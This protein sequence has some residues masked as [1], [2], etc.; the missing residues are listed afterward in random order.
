V[1]ERRRPTV[2]RRFVH[3]DDLFDNRIYGKGACILHMLRFTVGEELWLKGLRDYT[4]QYAFQSIETSQ[5]RRSFEESTGYNLERFFD[6]WIYGAG[7]PQFEISSKW[8]QALRSVILTVTQVQ[9]PDSLT[10]LFTTPVE[11]EVWVNGVPETYREMITGVT[12]EFTYPAYQE[13]QLVIF[14]KGSNLLKTAKFDKGIGQWI[15]QLRNADHVADRVAAISELRWMVDSATVKQALLEALIG[16]RAWGVRREAAWAL[17]D[18]KIP[19]GEE[20]LSAYGD[21][22]ARVRTAVIAALGKSGGEEVVRTLRRAFRSDS[23]Y[24]VSAR[25]LRSLVSADSLNG[26][27]YCYEGLTMDSYGDAIRSAA[28]RGL[29]RYRADESVRDTLIS[30][31]RLGRPRT[32]RVLSIAL[33]ARHWKDDDDV[34]DHLV[35]FLDDPGFRVRRAAVM[36]LGNT[37]YD[38]ALN[39]LRRRLVSEPNS[40]IQKAIREAIKKIEDKD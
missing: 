30:Y 29:A 10:G 23:S 13:P 24:N 8:D 34:L 9:I 4:A 20:M 27:E 36:N 40:R 2:T 14:D 15:F 28:L 22:N 5:L 6:Q 17:A 39:A 38:G 37:G 33:L 12:E 21:R 7:F 18:A 19:V 1:G 3:P 11:I 31:T 35:G 32:M 16:D 26:R 25:A